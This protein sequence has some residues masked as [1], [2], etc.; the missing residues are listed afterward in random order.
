MIGMQL[1]KQFGQNKLGM[2]YIIGGGIA[3]LSAIAAI[4]GV[5]ISWA[6]MLAKILAAAAGIMGM[7][8]A[9][10]SGPAMED[11][12][13]KQMNEQKIETSTTTHTSSISS[14]KILG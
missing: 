6:A 5:W 4:A 11:S 12:I 10:A 1:M 3:I 13:K 9:M 2:I 14:S 8:A 7:L